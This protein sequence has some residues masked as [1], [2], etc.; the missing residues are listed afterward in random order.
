M[1]TTQLTQLPFA[2]LE[3]AQTAFLVITHN[4]EIIY[5]NPACELLL[6]QSTQRLKAQTLAQLAEQFHFDKRYI[7]KVFKTHN[8]FTQSE[9]SLLIEG[10]PLLLN[11]SV[12]PLL[13]NE[14]AHVLIEMQ[15]ISQQRKSR[16]VYYQQHQQQVAQD[17]MRSLAHEIK[18]PLGGLRGAAQLLEAELGSEDLKEFTQ[19]IIQQADRLS[20]LVD[21]LLG[22]TAIGTRKRDNIHVA[23]EQ[24][25]KLVQID[26]PDSIHLHVDYDPSIPD[27]EMQSD[28]LQQAFLNIVQNAVQAL[29]SANTQNA[30]ITIRTRSAHQITINGRPQR[31][32]AEIK[33]TDNGPGISKH[34][35]DTLF[36]P[37][38]TG[39]EKGTG[40]GLSIAQ[41]LIKQHHGRIEYQSCSTQTEFL[42]YLPIIL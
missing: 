39:R 32:V 6:L 12:S 36:F 7:E 19:I 16:Q 35:Q 38:V 18:N 1:L 22:P 40:L 4:G 30:K 15:G 3:E 24:V 13:F 31:L 2:L 21:R 23:L 34:L 11:L 17:L 42:I 33:I 5:A 27:F 29:S 37:M 20:A 41:T 10:R 26:L 28:Q 8:A 14:Q 9:V 25:R